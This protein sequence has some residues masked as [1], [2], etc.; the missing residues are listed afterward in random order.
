MIRSREV[1]YW[2]ERGLALGLDRYRRYLA[3]FGLPLN[4]CAGLTVCDY[5][6]GP[7]GGVLSVLTDVRQAYPVDVLAATYNGW[8]R[9]SM[10]I[11]GVGAQG[12]A[13]V[14]D[15]SCAVAF[16]LNALD[17][18][19]DP[20]VMLADLSRILT[21]G[22]RLYLFVHLRTGAKG[23]YPMTYRQTMSLLAGWTIPWVG[24]GADRPNE[25]PDL[26]ALWLKAVRL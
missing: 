8:G 25:E 13:E 3:L 12:R 6:C 20:S 2:Q 10:Q 1:R 19:P 11:R 24:T 21:P 16:C 5:G 17:H 4:A 23:H 18:V 22:G 15:G 7:F 9:C 26:D 14:P